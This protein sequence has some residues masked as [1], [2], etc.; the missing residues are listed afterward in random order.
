MNGFAAAVVIK[1]TL[2][3]A[4]SLGIVFSLRAA[5]AALRHAILLV[6]L[7]GSLALPI[8]MLVSPSWN[9]P[10]L[11]AISANATNL[12]TSP[13]RQPD[14]RNLGGDL[15]TTAREAGSPVTSQAKGS[16]VLPNARNFGSSA[17]LALL[18]VFGTLAVL[19]WLATG[20][21]RLRRIASR[22]WPLDSADWQEA[23]R[24][25]GEIAG[26]GKQ[27]RLLAS[28]ETNTPLTWG[29]Q[30]PIILLPEDAP[31][32]QQEHRRVVLRHELAHVARGDAFAQLL[33]GVACSVYWFNPLVWIAERRLRA[34]CERACDDRVV[35]SGTPAPDYA[36]HLLEVARSARSF[37]GPGFLSVAMA[38]STQLEGR[39]LAVLDESRR[40][41]PLSSRDR[42]LVV[43]ASIAIVVMLC[44]FRP[45]SR[46]VVT[47]MSSA[48]ESQA[49]VAAPT[50]ANIPATA[51]NTPALI[52]NAPATAAYTPA[53]GALDVPTV[54]RSPA[55]STF[56]SSVPAQSG[57]TLTIE[58]NTT[59][60]ELI[61]TGWDESKVEVRGSLGGKS[62]RQTTVTLEPA[63]GGAVLR[64][65]YTGTA[66][67]SSFSHSFSIRVPRR[68]NV[69]VK[70]SGGGISI[71]DVAGSFTGST[72]GGDITLERASGEA[73]LKTGGGGINVANSELRGSVS[74]GGG[75]VRINGGSGELVGSSGTG[76]VVYS[77][78][79]GSASS[80]RTIPPNT[81]TTTI[82]TGD[83]PG[84]RF[85]QDGIQHHTGGG[86][87]TVREAP[88]GARVS[89]GGGAIRIGPSAGE[90]YASTGGGSITIGPASGSVVASTGAG[91]I[92]V[93]FRGAEL[94]AAKLTSGLGRIL[95]TL[96]ED[97]SGTL[98]L[99]T[100][101]TNN[102]G[103]KTEIESDW[104]LAVTETTEW[105]A[106]VGTPRKYV[107]ARK[108]FGSA[109]GVIRVRTVNGNIVVRRASKGE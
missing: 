47:N 33:A 25:E 40:R 56:D 44:A 4:L 2:M 27:V 41:T 77:D 108:V 97:F 30:R 49:G 19:A 106:S 6:A 73:N 14:T 85:G 16:S 70:S 45:V 29:L 103:H 15:S 57:G 9:L 67:N 7:T 101:Y 92:S 79:K 21:L 58:L 38:R 12:W 63:A 42:R 50:A 22:A 96:P 11:P 71:S 74:T 62:W 102:L 18:W 72:G 37:G 8:L 43:A 20:H 89:T 13:T 24:Q 61:I 34:E 83:D 52:S 53:K 28:P 81:G 99:E 107:R 17:G 93:E 84:G 86:D 10:V 64:S 26:V 54:P 32:W 91:N 87:I 51:A 48:R 65:H 75:A 109:G 35:A 55:D 31:D 100:A 95:L 1:A 105:D 59:G 5:T 23:L 76:N 68:F 80:G 3:I 88:R 69:R 66:R 94:H 78:T 36:A 60:G 104:P 82:L 90:V 98:A 46:G 39:L